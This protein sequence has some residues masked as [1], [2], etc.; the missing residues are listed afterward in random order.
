MNTSAF[1]HGRALERGASLIVV[2]LL[3]L[4]MTLLGLASLRG[5]LMEERM[6]SNALDRGLAFQAAETALREAQDKIA[7]AGV[8]NKNIGFNCDAVDEICNPTPSNAYTGNVAGCAVNDKE[9]W[10]N[11]TGSTLSTAAGSPQYYIEFMDE[12]TTAK[13]NQLGTETSANAMQYG[14]AGGVPLSRYYR[15][16]ARSNDPSAA[17]NRAVVVLQTTVERK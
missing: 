13:V 1:S 7:Q 2:L 5:T 4:I 17:T 9:C 3:L 8:Q 15:I 10:I 6:S 14:G 16:T 11:A 12:E